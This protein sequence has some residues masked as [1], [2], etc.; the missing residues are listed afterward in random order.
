MHA[1]KEHSG[2]DVNHFTFHHSDYTSSC[3]SSETPK[4]SLLHCETS[5]IRHDGLPT[6][7][8]VLGLTNA[9]LYKNFNEDFS[10]TD[11]YPDCVVRN[12]D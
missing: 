2:Q 5:L 9:K 7:V 12:W 4:K 8:D 10:E 1:N 6:R 3:N 11:A